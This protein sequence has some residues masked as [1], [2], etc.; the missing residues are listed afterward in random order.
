MNKMSKKL[1]RLYASLLITCISFCLVSCSDAGEK[2]VPMGANA[3]DLRQDD[4][5][6]ELLNNMDR[7]PDY[8]SPSTSPAAFYYK[9]DNWEASGKAFPGKFDLWEQGVVPEIRS[10]GIWGTCWSFATIAASEISLLSEM[11]L[12]T[13][14]Y[15]EEYGR[16]MDLSEKHLAWFAN[17]TIK[18][19]ELVPDQNGEGVRLYNGSDNPNEIYC[20]GGYSIYA[21]TAFSDGVGPVNDEVEPYV[22]KDGDSSIDADWSLEEE[23]RFLSGYELENSNIL[24]EPS[25]RDMDGNYVYNEKGTLAIKSELLNGRAV[26]IS[27][28]ADASWIKYTD[29]PD[30]E[31]NHAATIIG[32]DDNFPAADYEGDH[33]PPAD[34]AWIVRNSWSK[35]W[36]LD[37][38][39]YLSYYDASVCCA[40]SFDFLV[41]PDDIETVTINAYDYMPVFTCNT[42]LMERPVY[43]ANVFT[44][45]EDCVL[46]YVSAM[47][48]ESGTKVTFD[49]YL[50]DKNSA[51]P[52]DGILLDSR[53]ESFEFAG[54]H[55][56]P[57]SANFGLKEGDRIAV[58]TTE[59]VSYPNGKEFYEFIN[60]LNNSEE[61]LQLVMEK[62]PES[63]PDIYAT[64]IIN[65]GESFISFSEGK[66][67]DWADVVEEM[68]HSEGSSHFHE[69]D[70]LSIKT[71]S[72]MTAALRLFHK[73]GEWTEGSDGKKTA[74][75]EDCGYTI[76]EITR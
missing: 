67:Y 64:G 72:R 29:D 44:M 66:W 48:G 61:I 6:M 22:G 28:S 14:T 37:G 47:T 69:Y 76:T 63:D 46:E 75:C 59:K 32:W 34:G 23:D 13:E 73:F 7:L 70:N 26:S 43:S 62:Y 8:F 20:Y 60:G 30:A 54:Y 9:I 17:S 3:K 53:T 36:G 41:N 65:H 33:Q 19:N 5:F 49:V 12:T 52:T 24:P 1:K 21:S 50:L 15:R 18:D 51:S 4:G 42:S 27:Y 45:K 11:N 39:F 35:K 40:Q 16:D 38:Y 71:Y 10:Q 2:T 25:C 57:L 31:A 55:R 68:K 74:V 58:V 56:I